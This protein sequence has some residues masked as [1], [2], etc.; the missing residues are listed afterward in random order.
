[1]PDPRRLG[2]TLACL[3]A[4]AVGGLIGYWACFWLLRE[5]FYAIVLPGACLGMGCGLLARR[6]SLALGI[7]AA[8]AAVALGL[9]TEWRFWPFRADHSLG[10]FITHVH[11]LRAGTWLTI[12]FGGLFAFWFGRG[13][14]RDARAETPGET[15]PQ[16]GSA[17]YKATEEAP[18]PFWRG[19][20]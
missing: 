8:V 4:G 17:E 13:R 3:A 7:T 14:E 5:G 12:G 19:G 11:Q 16:E 15:P 20:G 10:F 6:S 2:N 18:F 1:M 9:F